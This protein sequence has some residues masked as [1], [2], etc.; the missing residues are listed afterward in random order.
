RCICYRALIAIGSMNGLL[1]APYIRKY[2]RM[3]RIE[4]EQRYRVVD[5]FMIGHVRARPANAADAERVGMAEGRTGGLLALTGICGKS[6][7]GLAVISRRSSKDL[8][9]LRQRYDQVGV[10]QRIIKHSFA[11]EASCY[12]AWILPPLHGPVEY[13]RSV[14]VVRNR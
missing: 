2:S 11:G 8:R 1:T 5:E 9:S 3:A 7:Y 10:Q 6:H 4:A 12:P 13:R 14:V